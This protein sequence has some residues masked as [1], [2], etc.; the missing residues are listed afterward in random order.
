MRQE[1][2]VSGSEEVSTL[3]RNPDGEALRNIVNQLSDERN[4]RDLYLKHCHM[5]TAQFNKRTTFLDIPGKVYDPYQH[6]VKT[7]TFCNS[8]T[9]KPDRS[10]VSGLRA[11][12]FGD[13]T[14][15]DG[16]WITPKLE[17]KPLDF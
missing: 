15:L 14:F 10:R 17:T 6:V 1:T 9:P 4:Q 5:S 3:G 8:T 12:E 16:S 11:E 2:R 13:L 7:S